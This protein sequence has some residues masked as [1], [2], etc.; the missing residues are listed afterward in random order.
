MDVERLGVSSVRAGTASNIIRE[1]AHMQDRWPGRSLRSISKKDIVA[2][3]QRRDENA[4]RRP[5]SPLGRLPGTDPSVAIEVGPAMRFEDI[6]SHEAIPP[7]SKADQ[8]GRFWKARVK[9]PFL[10]LTNGL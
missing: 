9:K 3:H 5:A 4:V 6:C 7:E 10:T 8:K 2:S 1:L